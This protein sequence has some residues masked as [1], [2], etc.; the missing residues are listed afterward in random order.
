[1][2]SALNHTHSFLRWIVLIVAI[3]T[4]YRYYTGWKSKRTFSI[5]D[6]R[7]GAVFVGTLHLQLVIGLLLYF[8]YSPV[9]KTALSSMSIAMKDPVLRFWAVEHITMMIIAVVVAQVGRIV[10]KKSKTDAEKYRKGFIYFLIAIIIILIA[11]PW[12]FRMEGIHRGWFP[13]M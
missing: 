10:S 6:N 9:V 13:G 12:P 1:M 5:G 7:L 2:Y 11:I 8:V 3:Y 4:I